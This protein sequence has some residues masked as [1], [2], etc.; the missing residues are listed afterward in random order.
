MGDGTRPGEISPG[1]CARD[2]LKRLIDIVGASVGLI[3]LSPI[4]IFVAASIAL[5]SP[6]SPIFSQ[7]R[8]GFA[9]RPFIILKFRSMKVCEDG[10]EIRQ[11]RRDDDRIT[12]VGQFIRRTSVDELPQLINVLR[13]DMSLVAH[14][15]FYGACIAGYEERFSVK[16]GLTGLAQVSGLRG[17][18]EDLSAMVAR[19]QKD[20]EYIASWSIWLDIKILFRTILIFAFHPAAY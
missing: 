6:G 7:R 10:P 18:T 1:R 14:D 20:R 4:L 17:R 16:P 15:A 9:G 8:T 19:V 5:E 3:V 2:P 13:G 11:A 12:R